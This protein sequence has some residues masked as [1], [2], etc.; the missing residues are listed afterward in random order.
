MKL[1][2]SDTSN[3]VRNLEEKIYLSEHSTYLIK[4]ALPRYAI[5]MKRQ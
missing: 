2:V 1:A 4:I 5:S 3:Y